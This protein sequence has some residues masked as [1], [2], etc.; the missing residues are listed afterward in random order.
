M[1][2]LT[3]AAVLALVILI[4]GFFLINN[5]NNIALNFYILCGYM[6]LGGS[7]KYI[8]EAYDESIFNKKI[9]LFLAAV[10]MFLLV[11]LVFI[12]Y[13]SGIIFIAVAVGLLGSGKIDNLIFRLL[14][15]SILISAV[16]RLLI[17]PVA[18]DLSSLS[19]ELF[20]F[21]AIAFSSFADEWLN[22]FSDRHKNSLIFVLKV[23]FHN[24]LITKITIL[25]FCI[26]G[27]KPNLYFMAFL[28]FDAAYSLID[29]LGDR[30]KEK[31]LRAKQNTL[32]PEVKI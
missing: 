12:D 32:Y 24:R 4:E 20:I 14:T 19:T 17:S 9:A 15:V 13:I 23:I 5:S 7:S 11:S 16:L 1:R 31:I 10:S 26:F 2:I 29:N 6:V 3:P 25:L 27:Y 28:G 18:I 8:D 21:I 30:V 22:D